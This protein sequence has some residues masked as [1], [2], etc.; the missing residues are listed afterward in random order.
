MITDITKAKRILERHYKEK[1]IAFVFGNGINRYN[2]SDD[3]N[4]SWND[5]LLKVWDSISSK[6]LSEIAKGITTTEFYNIMEFEAGSSKEVREKTV[7]IV[8]S[9]KQSDFEAALEKRLIDIDCPVLTT[10]FDGN[11]EKG[12]NRYKM[13]I[14]QG[15][16]DFYPW[17]V[18]YS[19]CQLNDPLDGFGVWHIN[20]MQ[21][22][23]RSLRLSLSEYINL[24]SRARNFIHSNEA[25]DN[26]DKKNKSMWNGYHTW[27]HLIF[28]SNLCIIGL[29]LDEQETFLRWLLIERIKY[30]K[31]FKDRK[32]QG[33]FVCL[34]EDIENQ[35]KKM[36][37]E[38]LG[39]EIICLSSYKDIYESLLKVSL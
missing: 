5:M 16:S 25:I 39:F 1:K 3:S 17:N 13:D 4:I 14:K 2:C 34:N 19:T 9:W 38:Y 10:N 7:E 33:W 32:R 26:F 8:K 21:D 35:G 12:L 24:T 29:A 11:I 18:Y 27:M 28:N 20:G 37:L 15:F 31:K 36:F 23:P 6:T 22:Y 30:F